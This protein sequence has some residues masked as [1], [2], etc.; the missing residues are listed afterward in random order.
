MDGRE[1]NRTAVNNSVVGWWSHPTPKKIVTCDR[2]VL[3]VLHVVAIYRLPRH[4][5]IWLVK[6]SAQI[7]RTEY[8]NKLIL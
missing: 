1:W 3:P 7:R 4:G 8:V 6:L 5:Q 2:I